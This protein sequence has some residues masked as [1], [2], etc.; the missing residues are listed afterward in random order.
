MSVSP[1]RFSSCLIYISP[2]LI[3]PLD[4]CYQW[5]VH[6]DIGRTCL[7]ERNWPHASVK[8]LS[9]SE[10][11]L[12]WA[13][14]RRVYLC[15][16]FLTQLGA[17][18]ISWRICEAVLGWWRISQMNLLF[19]WLRTFPLISISAQ[20]W[21]VTRSRF[22]A[23]VPHIKRICLSE[24]F[25]TS[26]ARYR[27]IQTRSSQSSLI[28]HIHSVQTLSRGQ[29][30]FFEN[31]ISLRTTWGIKSIRT[32]RQLHEI[33]NDKGL[34]GPLV[35]FIW[36]DSFVFCATHHE[37]DL[38]CSVFGEASP[39][40]S[41][42][43][44][45]QSLSGHKRQIQANIY[46]WIWFHRVSFI[47]LWTL[48]FL[49][50]FVAEQRRELNRN[51]GWLLWLFQRLYVPVWIPLPGNH[52]CAKFLCLGVCKSNTEVNVIE[53][54]ISPHWWVRLQAFR[55]DQ[56]WIHT[57]SLYTGRQPGS[58]EGKLVSLQFPFRK[59]R[60]W[61]LRTLLTRRE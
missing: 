23:C 54:N 58:G 7:L 14:Y 9:E 21:N 48:T 5:Q 17:E 37:I 35:L 51:Q 50:A 30:L 52:M 18:T 41:R 13:S 45:V 19:A 33:S 12:L 60:K 6:P 1:I 36:Q 15:V 8:S 57:D 47:T 4:F 3:K 49:E 44:H 59:R 34:C 25:E 42:A 16:K 22:A 29:W 40:L 43:V 55:Y 61:K 28:F 20:I 32:K 27:Y 26:S 2:T 46:R 53:A 11:S 38:F 31:D 10:V 39:L 24:P 56:R